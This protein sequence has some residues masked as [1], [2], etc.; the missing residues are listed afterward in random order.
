MP[1]RAEL[2]RVESIEYNAESP[3]E[4]GASPKEEAR[5]ILFSPRLRRGQRWSYGD[6]L[7]GWSVVDN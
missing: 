7:G 4:P 1:G 5:P 6:D 3:S 2:W